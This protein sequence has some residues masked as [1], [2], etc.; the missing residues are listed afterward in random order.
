MIIYIKLGKTRGLSFEINRNFGLKP[1]F[2]K[3]SLHHETIIDIPCGQI[4]FTSGRWVPKNIRTKKPVVTHTM[5]KRSASNVNS[6]NH[7]TTKRV[8]GVH[9]D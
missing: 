8:G 4:I 2:Q 1:F 9:R 6:Q 3:Y 7:Q 5:P